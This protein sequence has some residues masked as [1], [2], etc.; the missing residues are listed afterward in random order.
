MKNLKLR[1]ITVV[2]LLTLPL[3]G[4][5]QVTEYYT[6]QSPQKAYIPMTI[7]QTMCLI[8]SNNRQCKE[9]FSSLTF[10]VKDNQW[11]ASIVD[12]D[13]NKKEILSIQIIDCTIKSNKE[14]IFHISDGS[15]IS[16]MTLLV[17][18]NECSLNLILDSKSSLFFTSLGDNE[19]LTAIVRKG[20]SIHFK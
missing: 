18:P 17:S 15:S 5:C 9:M 6:S 14:Y 10:Q 16:K 7:F 2:L 3:K 12:L 8:E 11:I 4:I 1:I 20:N 13:E 19:E